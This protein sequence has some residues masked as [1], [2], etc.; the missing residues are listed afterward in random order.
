[1]R[2]LLRFSGCLRPEHIAIRTRNLLTSMQ[3]LLRRCGASSAH[4]L[5]L[6]GTRTGRVR[7]HRYERNLCDGS[8]VSLL[9][10]RPER[11]YLQHEQQLLHWN[12]LFRVV[13]RARS[14]AGSR[15]HRSLFPYDHQRVASLGCRVSI[16]SDASRVF[17]LRRF[18]SDASAAPE[19]SV[20]R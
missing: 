1:M 15:A 8:Q 5:Q 12:N 6:L 4:G 18:R 3:N 10:T 7:A 9:W 16:G 17:D 13:G 2:W 20:T 19:W 11:R 14:A